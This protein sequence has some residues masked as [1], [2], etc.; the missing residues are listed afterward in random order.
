MGV[1]GIATKNGIP[2]GDLYAGAGDGLPHIG[3]EIV[4]QEQLA[5]LGLAGAR[6]HGAVK[7]GQIL[8]L[9]LIGDVLGNAFP[10][11]GVIHGLDSLVDAEYGNQQHQQENPMPE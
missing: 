10:A 8:L 7:F 3:V 5:L 4:L 9:R 1:E 6:H 2:F 11:P